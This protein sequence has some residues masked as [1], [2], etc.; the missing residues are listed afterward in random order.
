MRP[1]FAAIVI[2]L[3]L[4]SSGW[5]MGSRPPVDDFVLPNLDGKQ[6][7][8]SDHRGKVVLLN[9][10]ASWC[11]PC[12]EEMPSLQKLYVK[13]KGRQFELLTVSVED[14][15]PV[16]I[17]AFLKKN[18]YTFKVLHDRNGEVASRYQIYAI[19]TTFL[20]DKNGRIV[21]RTVG[22]RDWSEPAIVNKIRILL[23]N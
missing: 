15:D 22:S 1:Y 5:G 18:G 21:E 9:F 17:R 14:E 23:K 3:L 13:L 2:L 11:P 19:P 6:V 4:A 7:M 12:R 20:L 10:W 16:V 8:L